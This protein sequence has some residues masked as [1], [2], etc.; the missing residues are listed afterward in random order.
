VWPNLQQT[1]TVRSPTTILGLAL[2]MLSI[3]TGRIVNAQP[4]E[5][6]RLP[7][8][9]RVFVDTSYPD[10]SKYT[11][12]IVRPKDNL[13]AVID[14]A[15]CG[16]VIE[17]PA[18]AT[19]LQAKPFVLPNKH[20]KETGWIIVRSSLA[21]V[22]LPAGG[23]V[24]PQQSAVLSRIVTVPPASAVITAAASSGYYRL[25][26]LEITSPVSNPSLTLV[27]LSGD[28]VTE[29]QYRHN[30][31]IDR[32]YVHGGEALEVR[33]G[34]AMGGVNNAVIDSHFSEIHTRGQ[35]SQAV[36]AWRGVGPYK[37]SNN[38]LSSS[39]ENLL[40][41]GEA[42][43]VSDTVPSDIEIL[44]NHFTKP[45]T[46]LPGHRLYAGHKWL[47]KNLL[48]LKNARRVLIEGNVFEHNWTDGQAGLAILFTPRNEGLHDYDD[49]LA[50][51]N[52]VEDVTFQF[53][54]LRHV[55]SG[56]NVSGADDIKGISEAA[57]R[58]AIQHN[59]FQDVGSFAAEGTAAGDCGRLLTSYDTKNGAPFDISTVHNTGFSSN[60]I[61][62]VGDRPAQKR[63]GYVIRDNIFARGSYGI[64]GSGSGEGSGTLADYFNG[65]IVTHNILGGCTG[66]CLSQYPHQNWGSANWSDVRFN[67]LLNCNSGTFSISACA[68]SPGSPYKRLASD[69]QD[70]GVDI[71]TLRDKVA[72]VAPSLL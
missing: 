21:D 14:K 32:C 50:T 10:T 53:N 13:Q 57:H 59:L 67:N 61:L 31:I 29:E 6:K 8:L 19:F 64:H 40:F 12:V 62:N 47:V 71:P 65:S 44:R 16:T 4:T 22:S 56:I 3:E 1:R 35:D 2:L 70:V 26:G 54:L 69:H 58:I 68:L 25:I 51:W 42:T 36:A 7:M 15:S 49:G 41:G 60:G 43:G 30:I 72:G 24:T 20:C 45:L 9:P 33:R 11:H 39:S 55:C 5:P 52:T 37:I 27:V 28:E 46:W 48:E 66:T 18:G 34:L 17:L 38:F 63:L 23:R